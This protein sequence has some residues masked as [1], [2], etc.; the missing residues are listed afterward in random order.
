MYC[1]AGSLFQNFVD[2]I[3]I[4]CT[5]HQKSEDQKRASLTKDLSQKLNLEADK[6]E[7]TGNKTSLVASDGDTQEATVTVLSR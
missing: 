4:H 2:I 5:T 7:E 1:L 6:P 3:R